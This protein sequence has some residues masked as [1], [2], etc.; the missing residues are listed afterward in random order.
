M[1]TPDDKEFRQSS[2]VAHTLRVVLVTNSDADKGVAISLV[3]GDTPAD[4]EPAQPA[5]GYVIETWQEAEEILQA[6][7]TL[8]YQA[9]GP[10]PGSKENPQSKGRLQ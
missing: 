8:C 10:R 2:L 7:H 9:F 3:P 4:A 5:P 1:T 6:L